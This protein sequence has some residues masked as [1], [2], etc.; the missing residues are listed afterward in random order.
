MQ[1]LEGNDRNQVNMICFEE[2][3]PANCFVRAVDVF[4]DAI[5]MASFGFENTNCKEEGRPAYHPAERMPTCS[6]AT[7][8]PI[9]KPA[10]SI[11]FAPQAKRTAG[12]LTVV[13]MPKMSR[14]TTP[15]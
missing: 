11:T 6:S 1:Y 4:V 9:A 10:K 2:L 12:P 15:G 3:I 8:P 13:S 14:P 7:S 5:D